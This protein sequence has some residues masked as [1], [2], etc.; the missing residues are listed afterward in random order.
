MKKMIVTVLALFCWTY[1][2]HA[3][4]L[5]SCADPRVIPAAAA[6]LNEW[7]GSRLQ[8]ASIVNLNIIG[9]QI[10]RLDS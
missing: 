1:P 3:Q 5:P 4:N 10:T 7:W 6:A 9:L 8:G 2:V